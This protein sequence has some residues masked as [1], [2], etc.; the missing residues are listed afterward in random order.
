MWTETN[1]EQEL[2]EGILRHGPEILEHCQSSDDLTKYLDHVRDE[3]LN[4]PIPKIADPTHWFIPKEYQ[5]MDI[6]QWVWN[7][8]DS[9][10]EERVFRVLTELEMFKKNDMI[11]VLKTIKYI[12]DTLR[13][14]KI[15]WG[16]GRGSSVASYVL[17]LIGVHKIDSI[18]YNLPIEE[19]FKEI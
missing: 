5:E 13:Q 9:E 16:V 19:F 10:N 6:E 11:P 1:T 15:V 8:V 7:Q 14:N 18:K 12:V 17:Y 3:R 2:I 4:Y